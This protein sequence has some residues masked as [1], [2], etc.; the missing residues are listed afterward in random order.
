MCVALV[1]RSNAAGT[2]PNRGVFDASISAVAVSVAVPAAMNESKNAS[3]NA[4]YMGQERPSSEMR[5]LVPSTD[6][7]NGKQSSQWQGC[8]EAR[9]NQISH[10]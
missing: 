1:L 9:S 6:G 5:V 7:C 4:E 3:L 2:M 8:I 10:R